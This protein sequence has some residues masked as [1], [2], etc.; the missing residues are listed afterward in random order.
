MIKNIRR[1][2]TAFQRE[3][4]IVFTATDLLLGTEI[5]VLWRFN[6]ENLTVYKMRIFFF[7][8][9]QQPKLHLECLIVDVSWLHTDTHTH[10]HTHTHTLKDSSDRCS[11]IHITQHTNIYA[12]SGILTHN[13][14]NQAPTDLCLI[15]HS[16]WDQQMK[17]YFR[18]LEIERGSELVYIQSVVQKFTHTPS[19]RNQ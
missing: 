8:V 2:I 18:H 16:H 19:T 10:T 17:T 1:R 12:L 9:A 15:P 14:G 5:F 13:P 7:L 11:Y 3:T 4:K 6:I